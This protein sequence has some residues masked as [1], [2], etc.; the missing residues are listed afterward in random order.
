MLPAADVPG[1]PPPH[2]RIWFDYAS[3]QMQA[4]NLADARA[5][6]QRI[7][8]SGVMR[9]GYPM[10]FVRSLYFLGQINERQGNAERARAFYRRFVQYWGDGEIDRERVA[11]ARKRLGTAQ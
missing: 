2:V 10:Q 8:D 6:F 11:D 1:P 4:G 3:A 9:A 7:V 5:R